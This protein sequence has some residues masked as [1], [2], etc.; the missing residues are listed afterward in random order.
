MT[1]EFV[2][3][4]WRN[5]IIVNGVNII[6]ELMEH[7]NRYTSCLALIYDQLLLSNSKMLSFSIFGY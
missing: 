2:Y 1:L 6:S 3:N 7:F 4:I 5:K